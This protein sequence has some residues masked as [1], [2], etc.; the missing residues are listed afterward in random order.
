[1]IKHIVKTLLTTCVASFTL[2]LVAS[3]TLAQVDM[4]RL[5]QVISTCRRDAQSEQ[6]YLNIKIPNN[7]ILNENHQK[8]ARV[9]IEECLK[10]RYHY[11]TILSKLPWLTSAEETLPKFPASVAVAMT[12]AGTSGRS[13]EAIMTM[14]DCMAS[15][16]SNSNDCKNTTFSYLLPFLSSTGDYRPLVTWFFKHCPMERPYSCNEVVNYYIYVCPSC[17]VIYDDNPNDRIILQ[18]FI[19]WFFAQS[20]EYRKEIVALI[21]NNSL[22][23]QLNA[24]ADQAVTQYRE[25]LTRLQ[26]QERERRRREML[27]Q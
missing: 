25:I 27:G 5:G 11:L 8:Y 19:D 7:F 13:N 6:Y 20:V 12:V 9:Y 3:K 17:T 16:N 24:E 1:M 2:Q 21:K 15:K 23:E 14:I 26:E 4:T 22:R 18:A 10:Y